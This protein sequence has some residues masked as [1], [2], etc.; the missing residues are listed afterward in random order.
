[1]LL[2]DLF[3]L[4]MVNYLMKNFS[5]IWYDVGFGDYIALFVVGVFCIASTILFTTW[6]ALFVPFVL[7]YLLSP[8][9][10]ISEF[11]VRR[12]AEYPKGPLLALSAFFG[13]VAAL[14]KSFA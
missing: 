5:N 8:I 14:L 3:T 12:I 4:G 7:A 13:A 2:I 10:F 9:L 6:A 1:M 11:V